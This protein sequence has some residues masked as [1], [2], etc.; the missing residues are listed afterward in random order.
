MAI[1][2]I[3]AYIE[4]SGLVATID[5]SAN[6]RIYRRP[7][8]N[9]VMSLG[10]MEEACSRFLR[11]KRDAQNLNREQVGMMIG[12]HAEIYARHE[13]AGA[14]LTVTRLL[15]LAELLGFSPIEA[16][17]AMAP[18][19]LGTDQEE[20]DMRLKLVSRVLALPA[21]AAEPLLEFLEQMSACQPVDH[22]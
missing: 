21:R 8:F 4:R 22:N 13:R 12:I 16:V 15:H 18:Q 11:Q 19:C 7:G 1:K 5:P 2:N 6:K 14:K 10:A 9:G 3:E 17:H 20:A